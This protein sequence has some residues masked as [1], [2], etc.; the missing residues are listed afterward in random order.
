M[1]LNGF[2]LFIC[3]ASRYCKK[4]IDSELIEQ[5]LVEDLKWSPEDA[6]WCRN[7]INIGLDILKVNK[8]LYL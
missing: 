4:K 3:A 1:I 5:Y 7:R 6:K 8:K 2:D